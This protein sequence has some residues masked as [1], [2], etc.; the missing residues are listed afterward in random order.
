MPDKKWNIVFKRSAFKEYRKLPK[1]VREKIDESFEILSISPFNELLN[2]RKIRGQN[3][4][5][6]IKVGDYRIVYTATPTT[7]AILIIRIGHR[8]DVYRFF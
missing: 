7:L 5:Y 8:K 2:F 6:R 1:R 3:N 4:H